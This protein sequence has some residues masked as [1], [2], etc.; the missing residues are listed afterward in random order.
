MTTWEEI[1]RQEETLNFIR[2]H[3]GDSLTYTLY[4]DL[5][6]MT[7]LEHVKADGSSEWLQRDDGSLVAIASYSSEGD[8]NDD[9]SQ[10]AWYDIVSH[11]IAFL[12]CYGPDVP[13]DYRCSPDCRI[14]KQEQATDE[15]DVFVCHP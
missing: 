13:Y 1:M 10:S 12:L 15:D 3:G 11:K 5:N 6:D 8:V 14:T 2:G 4:L 7:T 9:A